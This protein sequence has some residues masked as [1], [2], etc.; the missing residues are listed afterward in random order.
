MLKDQKVESSEQYTC[1][2]IPGLNMFSNNLKSD[3]TI[4]SDLI[5]QQNEQQQETG[6]Q[7]KFKRPQKVQLKHGKKKKS[8]SSKRNRTLSSQKR[9]STKT[10]S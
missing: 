8:R 6:K 3:P 9:K 7:N 4:T 10:E 1:Q 5:A 2:S